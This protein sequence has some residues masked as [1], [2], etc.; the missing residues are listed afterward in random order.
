MFLFLWSSIS[1]LAKSEDETDFHTPG[2]SENQNKSGEEVLITKRRFVHLVDKPWWVPAWRNIRLLEA[3]S[4]QA[5][6]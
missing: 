2:L 4:V 6:C 1:K 5:A 3:T